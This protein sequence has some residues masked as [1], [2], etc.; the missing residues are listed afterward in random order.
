MEYEI[1]QISRQIQSLNEIHNNE[2]GITETRHREIMDFLLTL[3]METDAKHDS[4][5]HLL[6]IILVALVFIAFKLK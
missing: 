1:K 5:K 2:I 3:K 4:I 6:Y